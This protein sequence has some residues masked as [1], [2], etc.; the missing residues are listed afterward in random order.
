MIETFL[1]V[2]VPVVL[3]VLMFGMGL[4]LVVDD[5]LRLARFPKAVFVGLLGQIIL[6]P[7]IAYLLVHFLPL[8]LAISAGIVILAACPG[9]V[10][11][12]SFSFLAGADV[13]LAVTLTA[14][15][16]VLALATM[17]LIVGLGLNIIQLTASEV[18]QTEAIGLPLAAT[19][20]QLFLVVVLPLSAGMLVRRFAER[21]AQR[22]GQWFRIANVAGLLVLLAGAF[23]VG[24]D[25]LLGNF[26]LLLP[27]LLGLNLA[28]MLGGFL[29]A[30]SFGLPAK[31]RQT[32]T[33]ELGVHNVGL[34]MLLALNV[35]QQPQW[36]V[37]PSV[38]SILMMLSAFAFI[39]G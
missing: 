26:K 16:S 23:T 34:G 3:T 8:P 5:F 29:L 37:V 32:I 10:A 12:N 24:F 27:L 22:S 15:S 1:R 2:F 9:G 4:Q 14:M 7:S 6:L 20:R 13:A 28:F 25:F 18:A 35:M 31:Q 36:I 30:R 17:P 39:G 21:L 11:S 19:V 38:Y 33:I